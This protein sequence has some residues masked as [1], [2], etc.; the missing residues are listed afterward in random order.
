[1]NQEA[2]M[3]HHTIKAMVYTTQVLG[4]GSM[5]LFVVFLFW[6]SF[7]CIPLGLEP[8][9][10]LAVDAL[11]CM[12]FFLQHSI[13][14]RTGVRQRLAKIIPENY[15]NAFYAATSGIALFITLLLWQ[16]IPGT[17]VQAD[18]IMH[19]L[20]RGLFFL[21]L[22]GFHWGAKSLGSFDP[23][24]VSRLKRL[25]RGRETMTLPLTIK[26]PYR[27]LRHPLYFFMLMMLWSVPGLTRDRL[28]FNILWT[29]WIII[30]TWLE[31]RDLVHEFGQPY[32]EY[33]ATV[34]MLIPYRWPA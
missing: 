28:L 20:L 13:M 34:P 8:A 7:T 10:A 6:G 21:C 31:E 24:G 11:L 5:L 12:L 9:A 33:Q 16:K 19:R 32:R 17:M 29:L 25:M 14:V 2:R 15:Y 26:G 23:L 22:L 1:M 30:A 18:G 27:W 3:R 4:L